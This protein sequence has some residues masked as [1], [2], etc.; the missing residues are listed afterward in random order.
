MCAAAADIYLLR[1]RQEPDHRLRNGQRAQLH[2]RCLYVNGGGRGRQFQQMVMEPIQM[3][4]FAPRALGRRC[5]E[6]RVCQQ[7]LQQGLGGFTGG[8][9]LS[10]VI[11]VACIVMPHPLVKQRVA[12]AG[13]EAA[14]R[15]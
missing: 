1:L 3:E 15:L 13:V 2:E 6:V 11:A 14:H 4:M 5:R 7:L 12:R 10:R 9:P 8:G